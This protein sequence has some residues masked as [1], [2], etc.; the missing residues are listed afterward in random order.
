MKM[1]PILTYSIFRSY[2]PYSTL[3]LGRIL[4][5]LSFILLLLLLFGFLFVHVQLPLRESGRRPLLLEGVLRAW[6]HLTVRLSLPGVADVLGHPGSHA[7]G[8][9]LSFA[10]PPLGD[11]IDRR[12]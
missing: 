3:N 5:H 10:R 11:E 1:N 4:F 2:I 7:P 9:G 6:R 12:V 8:V